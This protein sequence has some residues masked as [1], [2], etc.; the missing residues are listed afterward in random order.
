[1]PFN[2][3]LYNETEV[4]QGFTKL[5]PGIYLCRV[6]DFK[7]EEEKQ[8]LRIKFD[9]VEGKFKD[10]FGQS[11]KQFGEWPRDGFEIRSYKDTAMPFF[12][13]FI[14]ALEK[15]NAGY[16][17]SRTYDFATIRNKTFVG[18][19][20]EEEI[21]FPDDNGKPIVKVRL[22]KIASTDRL[23]QGEIKIPERKVLSDD[24]REKLEKQLYTDKV[25][26]ERKNAQQPTQL[27]KEED[28]PY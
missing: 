16:S 4:S 26:A 14:T 12:K 2:K 7:D 9:I 25:V 19:F 1:M 10:Y 21:P 27:A 5:E 17:F 3:D 6:L 18:I 8:Y 11:E 24:D 22:Q 28:L 20:G 15:S 23:A 13:G